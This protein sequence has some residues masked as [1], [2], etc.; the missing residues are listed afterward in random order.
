LRILHPDPPLGAP[1]RLVLN[2]L[3]RLGGVMRDLDVMTPR[4][5]AAR[6]G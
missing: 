2:Q 4:L 5:L 3:A 1:E 6:G